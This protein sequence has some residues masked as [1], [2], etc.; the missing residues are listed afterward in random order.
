MISQFQIFH[1]VNHNSKRISLGYNQ[2]YGNEYGNKK[3]K[4]IYTFYI[5]YYFSYVTVS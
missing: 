3:K 1:F 2:K 5:Q 4:P